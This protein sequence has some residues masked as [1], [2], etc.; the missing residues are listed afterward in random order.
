MTRF[1]GLDYHGRKPVQVSVGEL[2]PKY[3]GE[4][5]EIAVLQNICI[6]V[7]AQV[8]ELM[9]HGTGRQSSDG[10]LAIPRTPQV[11]GASTKYFL[12][13]LAVVKWPR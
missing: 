9:H 5:G 12:S 4:P 1:I 10:L 2:C 3:W 7:Y 6:P 11:S 8:E 13:S